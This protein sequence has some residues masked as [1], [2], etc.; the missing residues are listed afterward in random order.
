MIIFQLQCDRGHDFEGWFQ[1]HTGFQDQLDR[2]LIQCPTCGSSSINQRLA[3]GGVVRAREDGDK[4][5]IDRH[6]FLRAI[7]EVIETHFDNVG[8]EFAKTALRIHY[9]AEEGRNIRG[10][11]TD[12][13]EQLLQEEGVEF[14]KLPIPDPAGEPQVH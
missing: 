13:E 2:S 8:P 7:Q 12:A 11:T 14:F 10:T 4:P 9:G 3:T 6:A 1:D 5:G